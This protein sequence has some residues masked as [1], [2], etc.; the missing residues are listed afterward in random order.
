MIFPYISQVR[1]NNCYRYQDFLIPEQPLDEFRHIVL[2]GHNGAGKTTLLNRMF[3]LLS[4]AVLGQIRTRE[5]SNR[6]IKIKNALG[7]KR[8]SQ[9]AREISELN[10]IAIA[11]LGDEG[12]LHRKGDE[13]IIAHY[14]ADRKIVLS[15]VCKTNQSA[16]LIDTLTPILRTVFADSHLVLEFTQP[17]TQEGAELS[18]VFEDRRKITFDQLSAG[19]SAF[20]HIVMDLIVRTDIIRTVLKDN[21]F[22]P[23]GIVLIDEPEIHLQMSMQHQLLPLLSQ[24]FPNIQFIVATH[25]GAVISSLENAIV[26]DV[27]SKKEVSNLVIDSSFNTT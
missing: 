8:V 6:Q 1:V 15:P 16:A 12:A 18:L 26:Y 5:I 7:D 4:T 25:S 11:Y 3:L 17:L 2:T 22:R 13:Q 23:L 9:W 10:D 27:G 14:P 20:L 19:Y 21:T 24:F